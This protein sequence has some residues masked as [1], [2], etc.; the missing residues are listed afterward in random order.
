M[1]AKLSD[2][3]LWF[4]L[5][6]TVDDVLLTKL[7]VGLGKKAM[8]DCNRIFERQ[9][10]RTETRD[11]GSED[12]W[13]DLVTI[14]TVTSVKEASNL[15]FAGVD[16]LVENS[17]YYVDKEKGKLHRMGDIRWLSGRYTV[18]YI[19]TGGWLDPATTPVPAGAEL[20]PDDVQDA[21]VTQ[22]RFLWKRKED[23]GLT[24]VGAGGGSWTIVQKTPWL[25][26]VWDV[27]SKLKRF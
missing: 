2:L 27:L 19:Y 13:T 9:V 23:I 16:D 25:P 12:I 4:K 21:I 14:E 18:R 10:S 22:A 20:V 3:K 11:G 15:D 24:S 5:T 7:L 1:L 8:R 26:E 17:D 6:D